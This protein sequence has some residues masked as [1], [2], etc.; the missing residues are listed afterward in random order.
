M[1]RVQKACEIQHTAGL[2]VNDIY[3]TGCMLR[4]EEMQLKTQDKGQMCQICHTVCTDG[5]NS[6]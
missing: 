1:C 5:S 4:V 2:Q 3:N 6:P